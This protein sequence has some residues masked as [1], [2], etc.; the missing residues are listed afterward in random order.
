MSGANVAPLP[1]ILRAAPNPVL[2]S[3]A[4]KTMSGSLAISAGSFRNIFELNIPCGSSHLRQVCSED[5]ARDEFEEHFFECYR[6]RYAS[7][8]VSP[9]DLCLQPGLRE[10][11]SQAPVCPLLRPLYKHLL[12]APK[13]K[14]NGCYA[15]RSV[16][17]GV[18]SSSHEFEKVIRSDVACM[19]FR[20]QR[21]KE[22]I[23]RLDMDPFSYQIQNVEHICSVS[24]PFF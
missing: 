2:M 21:R 14:K 22:S 3:Q 10:S 15:H 23:I 13:V 24:S 12:V 17:R 16:Q 9:D 5:S 4:M 11:K 1:A 20:D 8:L 18:A 7:V 6:P 19:A